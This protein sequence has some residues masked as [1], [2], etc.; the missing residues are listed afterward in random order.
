MFINIV[1]TIAL[2]LEVTKGYFVK[3]KVFLGKPL[4]DVTTTNIS[5]FVQETD[6]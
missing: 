1:H 2:C 5:V 6:A 4:I 3:N